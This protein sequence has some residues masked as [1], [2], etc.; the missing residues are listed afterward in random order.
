M[1]F[2]YKGYKN[3]TNH[4]ACYYG[5]MTPISDNLGSS[6]TY[7]LNGMTFSCML[8][9]ILLPP[10]TKGITLTFFYSISDYHHYYYYYCLFLFST[11]QKGQKDTSGPGLA[12]VL[13]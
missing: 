5:W 4:K 1:Y 8:E 11:L 6:P 3:V 2:W 10:H 12:R 13:P 7:T 9:Y